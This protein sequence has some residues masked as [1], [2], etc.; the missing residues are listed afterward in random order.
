MHEAWC[1]YMNR[2]IW[3]RGAGIVGATPSSAFIRVQHRRRYSSATRSVPM[4]VLV[5]GQPLSAIDARDTL[6]I[7]VFCRTLTAGGMSPYRAKYG[8]CVTAT[9]VSVQGGNH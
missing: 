7:P 6:K 8:H 2:M 9:A 3:S 5:V 4:L 1:D